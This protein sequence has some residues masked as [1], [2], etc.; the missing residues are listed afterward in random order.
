M[1]VWIS[2]GAVIFMMHSVPKYPVVYRTLR[3]DKF[4]YGF[5]IHFIF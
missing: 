2:L 3:V 4:K 5:I 1:I